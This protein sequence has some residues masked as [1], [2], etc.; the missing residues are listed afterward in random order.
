MF[1]SKAN[2][3]D[4]RRRESLTRVPV[5]RLLLQTDSPHLQMSHGIVNTPAFLGDVAK[6]V[7][8]IR[9]VLMEDLFE[10]S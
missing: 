8:H 2:T 7:A 4:F 3:F 6:A 5:E 1:T 10:D 9:M